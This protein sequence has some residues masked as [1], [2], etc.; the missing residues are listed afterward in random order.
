[1]VLSL[2]PVFLSLLVL[3]SWVVVFSSEQKRGADSVATVLYAV[4]M[5]LAQIAMTSQIAGWLHLYTWPVVYG[6]NAAMAGYI[7]WK[8][9]DAVGWETGW[10]A[11]IRSHQMIPKIFL[12]LVCCTGLWHLVVAAVMNDA[13]FDSINYHLAWAAHAVQEGHL[14]PFSTPVVWINVYPKTLDLWYAWFLLIPGNDWLVDSAQLPFVWLGVLASYG[15]LRRLQYKNNTAL[16][17]A[18]LFAFAPIVMQQATTNY[19]DLALGGLV[20]VALFCALEPKA[21][22]LAALLLG[23]TGGLLIGGKATMIIPWT[24]ITA[25]FLWRMRGVPKK[26]KPTPAV[27]VGL[28]LLP[29][30]AIAHYWYLR[31][32][33]LYGAPLYPLHIT[34]GPLVL[35]PGTITP[36]D[37]ARISQ[38]LSVYDAPLLKHLWLNTFAEAAPT[39]NMAPGGFGPLWAFLM[40]PLLP[41]VFW[42]WKNLMPVFGILWLIWLLMPANWSLRFVIPLFF[43]GILLCAEALDWS[44]QGRRWIHRTLLGYT[45]L[46]AVASVAIAWWPSGVGSAV[47]QTAFNRHAPERDFSYALGSI[48]GVISEHQKPGTTI[49]YDS[50]WFRVYPLWN[51][52]RSNQVVHIPLSEDWIDDLHA[53]EVDYIAIKTNGPEYQWILQAPEK[54]RQ[55]AQDGIYGFYTVL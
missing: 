37:L 32:I 42:R 20:L 30:F 12:A 10:I 44:A 24:L 26:R 13:S 39:Y 43:A 14:G 3:A 35:H 51:A 34:L 8:N 25:L 18:S 11:D 54:F 46:L 52:E 33:L 49:A 16:I 17:A 1:M 31:N 45:M 6:V 7:L 55:L 21:V 29:C 27:L 15:I 5:T 41:V 53:Q 47:L 36:A 40:T 2:I 28:L 19:I 23:I 50:T 22:R 38:P 4:V 9:R 48:F